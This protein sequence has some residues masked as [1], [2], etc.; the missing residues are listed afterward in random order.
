[1]TLPKQ[2]CLIQEEHFSSSHETR[3]QH[4]K[5]TYQFAIYNKLYINYN[6]NVSSKLN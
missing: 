6:L 1:M 4:K 5:R 2:P 3:L